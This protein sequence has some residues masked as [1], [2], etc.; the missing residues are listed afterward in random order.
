MSTEIEWTDEVWNP[1]RGCSKVST[2]CERCYAMRQAHRFSGEGQPYEGLTKIV[3]GKGPQWTGRVR[4]VSEML[5]RPL[6]WRK[7]RRVFVNSMSDLFHE[8]VPFEFVDRVYDVMCKAPQHTFQILTKRP[9]RMVAFFNEQEEGGHPLRP[10]LPNVWLGTSVE[11]QAAADERIP[12]LLRTPAAIRFLSCEPLLGPVDLRPYVT[13]L[14]GMLACPACGYRTN[15]FGRCPNDHSE[16]VRD[17]GVDWV[18]IGGES[19]PGARPCDVRWIRDLVRQCR[20]AGV[21]PFVKQLGAQPV[22]TRPMPSDAWPDSDVEYSIRLQDAKGGDWSEW[23][24]DL[25]VR[26]MPAV[27]EVAR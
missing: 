13:S 22:E 10:F 7:P 23:T 27:V 18:I 4:T 1:V 5:E 21:A 6:R 14:D 20:E 8:D 16:L 2:G 17:F 25:R 3:K 19:G 26:E 24:E 15:T 11:N 9:E 12:H